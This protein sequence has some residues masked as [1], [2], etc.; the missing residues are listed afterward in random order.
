MIDEL[1]KMLSEKNTDEI[2][3]KGLELA[4]QVKTV[5][6][7]VQPASTQIGMDIWENCAKVLSER[8]DQ[9]L[10]PI[11]GRL[12]GWLR[13]ATLPGAIIIAKRLNAFAQSDQFSYRLRITK[14]FAQS[15]KE[16]HYLHNIEQWVERGDFSD[17]EE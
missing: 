10:E 11:L 5:S 7:F 9:E 4:R 6:I 2:Q 12:F 1:L 14:R 13:D 3:Q 15:R 16:D 17:I 8:T